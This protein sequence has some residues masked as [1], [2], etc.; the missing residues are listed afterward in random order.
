MKYQK[1]YFLWIGIISISFI[2]VLYLLFL[3]PSSNDEHDGVKYRSQNVRIVMGADIKG[4]NPTMVEHTSTAYG[5][6]IFNCLHDTLIYKEIDGKKVSHLL[7]T[8]PVKNG[9]ELTCE[10]RDDIF[11]HNGNPLKTDDVIFTI[12]LGKT[13]NHPQFQDMEN[14]ERIDDKKFKITLRDDTVW[15]DFALF[16]FIRIL[17]KAAVVQDQNKG[18]KIG[19]GPYKFINYEPN[20]KIELEL[21]DKYY[22]K[23]AI[24]T[25]PLKITFEIIRDS[26]TSL[27]KLEQKEV[28]CISYD[29]DKINDLQTRIDKNQISGIKIISFPQ[30]SASYIYLNKRKTDEQTRLAIAHALDFS[31]IIKELNIPGEPLNSYLPSSLKGA[32]NELKNRFNIEEARRIVSTLSTNQKKIIFGAGNSGSDAI[33]R[34]VTE[35]LKS[36]GFDA[37]FERIDFNTLISSVDNYNGIF[38]GENHEMEY[39]HKAL[40]DYFRTNVEENFSRVDIND[41][42]NTDDKLDQAKQQTDINEYIRLIKEVVKYLYDKSYVLSISQ[43]N[44]YLVVNDKVQRGFESDFF[45]NMKLTNIFIKK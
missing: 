14:V 23:E 43:N 38:L 39:G 22:D 18:L 8:M 5:A 21:F 12:N 15:Y 9:K 33:Q 2:L 16:R 37:T 28:D 44:K 40:D 45:G 1:N 32:N 26:N 7:K 36:V 29:Y 35:Q 10:L 25:S 19:A 13:N 6:Q 17:N 27:M 24:K 42:H 11:F 20:S 4:W 41:K 31:S 30:A 34:K 3:N